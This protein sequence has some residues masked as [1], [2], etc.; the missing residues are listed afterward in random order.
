VLQLRAAMQTTTDSPREIFVELEA[1]ETEWEYA[2][3]RKV[4]A[5]GFGGIVPGPTIVARVG[6]TLVARLVNRLPEATIVHWHGVRVPADMDGTQ[7]VQ[8]VVA[9][10]ETFEYRFTFPDA[11]TYWYHS[12]A[13]ETVQVER[14]LY[15]AIVVHGDAEPVFDADRV[16]VL[17]DLKLDRKGR[18][19]GTKFMER[20][21]GREGD[22][23]LINGQ[24]E[25]ELTI[26]AGQVERWRFINA[27]N[28]RY[29]KLSLGGRPFRVI[30]GDNGLRPQQ[31]VTDVMI[32]PGERVELA[33]GPFG[34]EGA[35]I[36]IES[37]PYSRGMGNK[38]RYSKWGTLR[39]G[40]RKPSRASVAWQLPTVEPLVPPGPVTPTRE[41]RFEGK[42]SWRFVDWK[43]NGTTHFHD[44]PVKVGE[45]QIWEI[46]N[47]TGMDHPFHL[48]GFFFQVIAIDGKRITPQAWDDTFNVPKKSRI[49][50]AWVAD[51][52]PG[53]WM[54][55]CHILEHHAAGMMGHFKVVR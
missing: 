18:I 13:N 12:H 26:A 39:V 11:G 15:G 43:I 41:I 23:T 35:S 52:R 29:V 33:V 16:L 9:P 53:M 5:W 42:M 19:A 48:H 34:D 1:R 8:T 28:A 37:L 20:H 7:C 38:P 44:A 22:V 50:I 4:M 31:T 36:A 49:T 14:G 40:P 21:D 2:P 17:D 47:T 54:Y 24:N 51:D 25:P 10:G 3:G 30:G 6:D 27:C 32:T 45:L 46:V 55:H